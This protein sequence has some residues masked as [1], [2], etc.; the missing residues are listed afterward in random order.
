MVRMTGLPSGPLRGVP[1]AS[2]TMEWPPNQVALGL[3]LANR[4]RPEAR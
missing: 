4:Q 3:P 1:S 2:H